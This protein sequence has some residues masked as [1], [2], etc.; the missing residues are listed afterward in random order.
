M[1]WQHMIHPLGLKNIKMNNDGLA[2]HD[3]LT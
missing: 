1:G 3:A 2:T